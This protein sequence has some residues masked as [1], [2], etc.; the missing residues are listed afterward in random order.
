MA[1]V[2][3]EAL[4]VEAVLLGLTGSDINHYVVSGQA[5]AREEYVKECEL[6]FLNWKTEKQER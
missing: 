2:S 5:A 1:D 6:A 4:K 3:L